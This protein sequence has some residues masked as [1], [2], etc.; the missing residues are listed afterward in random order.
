MIY[1]TI[2]FIRWDENNRAV[3]AAEPIDGSIEIKAGNLE[4][5]NTLWDAAKGCY[6]FCIKDDLTGKQCVQIVD[7]VAIRKSPCIVEG[8]E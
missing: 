8:E 7:S 2:K 4:A 6:S 1:Y 5:E 3:F